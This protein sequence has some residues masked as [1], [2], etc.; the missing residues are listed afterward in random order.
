MATPI[1]ILGAG[2]SGLMLGRML[3]LA[4]IDYIIF[5]RDISGNETSSRAGTLD[6]HANSGQVALQEAG[7]L[8]RFKQLARTDAHT[9]LADGQGKVYIRTG[10]RDDANEDRPEI[11]RKDLRA[12]LLSSVP[13][14]KVRWGCKVQQVQQD[15]DGSMSV[16]FADGRVES[17]FRLVVGADGAWSKARNLVTSAKPEYSGIHY[18]T[19]TISLGNPFHESVAAL[20][21]QG[22]YIAFGAGKQIVV[23]K[24]GDGAYYVG[25]G[26]RLPE[27]WSTDNATILE[28]PSALRQ[29]LCDEHFADWPQ[30]HT[31]LITCS[32]GKVYA[33]PL[34]T[35]PTASLPWTTVSGITLVGD[36]AHLSPPFVGEGVNCAL[37]DSLE[38][39]R[40][41]IKYG[42]NDLDRA[43]AE[44][45]KLMVPRAIDLITRSHR[46]GELF[47]APDA[48][49][50]WLKAFAGVDIDEWASE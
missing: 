25:V 29:W 26:L 37:T 23:F 33:W 8:D 32:D 22:N 5:E 50:G 15:P 17:G 3:E 20:A 44:Y 35:V 34:Y 31:D 1:A 47:F 39:A 11:D 21:G 16:Q 48:P 46:S 43:V 38:L 49:R 12:L 18:L 13:E 9:V 30:V 19:T 42:V 36:A 27:R 28:N 45:E 2:P 4:N 14:N 7:L 24:L 6:I 10:D 40:Q 41:I